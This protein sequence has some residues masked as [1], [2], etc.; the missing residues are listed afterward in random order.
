[1]LP[2]LV[3][4]TSIVVQPHCF[5]SCIIIHVSGIWQAFVQVMTCAGLLAGKEE[6]EP[7]AVL[8][9]RR[10]EPVVAPPQDITC[11]DILLAMEAHS[12]GVTPSVLA[13]HM[14]AQRATTDSASDAGSF[15]VV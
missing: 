10:K 15:V 13:A 11:T 1:M 12:E 7:L 6:A 14:A 5:V 2:A 8:V 3:G 9:R 4:R